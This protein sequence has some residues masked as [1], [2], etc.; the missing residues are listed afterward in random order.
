MVRGAVLNLLDFARDGAPGGSDDV[1]VEEV[2]LAVS[3]V[4]FL[5]RF[6]WT[7]HAEI[8]AAV[9]AAKQQLRL[10]LRRARARS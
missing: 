3:T 4:R 6:G 9:Q 1:D 7:L 5:E 2:E 8:A 10:L